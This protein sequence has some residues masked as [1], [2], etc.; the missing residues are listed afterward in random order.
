MSSIYGNVRLGVPK[1]TLSPKP[2]YVY[3]DEWSF[4]FH[5][6][7]TTI[8]LLMCVALVTFTDYIG[9]RMHCL[10]VTLGDNTI[11]QS[12]F[13]ETY[14][15]IRSTYTVREEICQ[16]FAY[17]CWFLLVFC[18]YSISHNQ[19]CQLFY[20]TL[21]FST[22]IYRFILTIELEVIICRKWPEDRSIFLEKQE[23]CLMVTIP[24]SLSFYSF[25]LFSSISRISCGN[26]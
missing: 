15:F 12:G 11:I 2:E 17:L 25:W 20:G 26:V 5:Y 23:R 10:P 19:N 16:S 1:G 18:F 13:L 4:R 7:F 22:Y 6:R 3:I 14:C 8:L 24:G 9:S 21:F